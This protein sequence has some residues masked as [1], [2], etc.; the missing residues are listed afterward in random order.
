VILRPRSDALDV[1]LGAAAAPQELAWI[2]RRAPE[3]PPT[4][5]YWMADG[6]VVPVRE[7]RRHGPLQ[8][9]RRCVR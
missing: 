9:R 8:I 7:A 4:A 2:A 1:A 3:R 6:V 5:P